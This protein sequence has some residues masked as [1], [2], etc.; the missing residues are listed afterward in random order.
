VLELARDSGLDV[1]ERRVSLTE[2]Y[3]AQEV[4]TTGTMG[5]LA[6]VVEIDGRS[7]GSSHAMGPVTSQLQTLYQKHI[8]NHAVPLP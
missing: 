6:H 1:Q 4:F 2:F 3:T 5:G 7:I 8:W